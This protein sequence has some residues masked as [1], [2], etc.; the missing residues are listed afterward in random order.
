MTR[1]KITLTVTSSCKK[2]SDANPDKLGRWNYM[3]DHGGL[4]INGSGS[5]VD[6]NMTAYA[7]NLR[8]IIEAMASLR[9]PCFITIRTRDQA[10]GQTAEGIKALGWNPRGRKPWA[11]TDLWRTLV[12]VAN[13]GGHKLA[14]EHF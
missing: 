3:I 5:I 4:V 11:Q 1:Y 14:F 13:E 6:E 12:K 10:V 9:N 2:A 8:G 7:A